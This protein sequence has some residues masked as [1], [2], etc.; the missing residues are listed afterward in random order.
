MKELV[1]PEGAV[2]FSK[3]FE[4]GDDSISTLELWGAE[5]Q[6]NNA[7]L[8]HTDDVPLLNEI[9]HRERCP[10]NVVGTVTGTGR[11]GF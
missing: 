8:C 11:V 5:Y 9:A 10:F 2:I 1:E 4:L 7:I 6:E 3:A